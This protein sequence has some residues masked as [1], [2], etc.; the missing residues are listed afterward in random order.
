MQTERCC[1]L[2]RCCNCVNAGRLPSATQTT[3]KKAEARTCERTTKTNEQENVGWLGRMQVG[4]STDRLLFEVLS[5][6]RAIIGGQCLCPLHDWA[7]YDRDAMGERGTYQSL[8]HRPRLL[9]QMAW[10]YALRVEVLRRSQG[11][12]LFRRCLRGARTVE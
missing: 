3:K 9:K 11:G 5:C 2:V 6:S 10:Q 7:R 4:L 1:S 8:G 12:L